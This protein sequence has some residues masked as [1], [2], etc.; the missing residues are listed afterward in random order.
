MSA[1]AGSAS[2]AF[3]SIA[4]RLR[5]RRRKGSSAP[6][7]RVDCERRDGFHEA[8]RALCTEHKPNQ[9][10]PPRHSPPRRA[11]ARMRGRDDDAD[12]DVFNAHRDA[13][14]GAKARTRTGIPRERRRRAR[15]EIATIRATDA[16]GST[17]TTQDARESS[18]ISRDST[19]TR[20]GRGWTS[21][22]S[23]TLTTISTNQTSGDAAPETRRRRRRRR[24]GPPRSGETSCRR[25]TTTSRTISR[26]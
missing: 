10:N 2:S 8:A 19:R 12:A 14:D 16:S 9:I 23:T 17:S 13:R 4:A 22:S 18:D 1:V 21:G 20:D 25:W 7:A 11:R 6:F 3:S 26:C 15:D 5:F 24:P